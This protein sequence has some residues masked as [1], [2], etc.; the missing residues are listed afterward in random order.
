M[1]ERRGT[2]REGSG[3]SVVP[4]QG[5]DTGSNPRWD[6]Q[7]KRVSA[8]PLVPHISRTSEAS[9]RWN[10]VRESRYD[11]NAADPAIRQISRHELDAHGG[12]SQIG[13]FSVSTNLASQIWLNANDAN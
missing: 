12:I 11:P 9:P 4:S 1:N 5:G 8:A 10:R 7:R 2:V 13:D 3:R 6:Y